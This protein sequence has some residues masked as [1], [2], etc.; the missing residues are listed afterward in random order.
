MDK[1]FDNRVFRFEMPNS[2]RFWVWFLEN[3]GPG[4]LFFTETRFDTYWWH[5]EV[6][7]EYKRYPLK[8]E[9]PIESLL[10]FENPEVRKKAKEFLKDS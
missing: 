4:F 10:T 7:E 1:K 6:R 9:I 3:P 8:T 2:E 5:Y